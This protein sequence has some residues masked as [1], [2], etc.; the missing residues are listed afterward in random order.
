MNIHAFTPRRLARVILVIG[1]ALTLAACAAGGAGGAKTK[2]AEQTRAERSIAR[3]NF[4]INGDPGSA[5]DYLTPGY[6]AINPRNTYIKETLVKPIHWTGIRYMNETCSTDTTCSV[7]LMID[8]QL[9]S[10][11]SGV[12]VIDST[13]IIRETWVKSDGIWYFL[14]PTE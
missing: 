6:R 9:R 8:Y 2:P 7:S 10:H 5:W 14:P 3:W 4:L 13:S 12:G 11:L 1:V